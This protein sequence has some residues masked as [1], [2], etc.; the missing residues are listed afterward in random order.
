[1]GSERLTL[2]I[3]L[4]ATK[5]YKI[6]KEDNRNFILSNEKTI[7]YIGNWVEQRNFLLVL[8]LNENI[9]NIRKQLQ[10]LQDILLNNPSDII[11]DFENK[12]RAVPDEIKQR[13]RK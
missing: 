3:K 5:N 7:Y 6:I 10:F 8:W 13:F 2:S 4:D 1:M 12:G 9:L 11:A